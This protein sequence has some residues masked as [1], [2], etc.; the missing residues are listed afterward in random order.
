MDVL[1]GQCVVLCGILRRFNKNVGFI[2][3]DVFDPNYTYWTVK[4]FLFT[5]MY[6]SFVASAYFTLLN[7]DDFVDMV[8]CLLGFGYI[9]QAAYKI[10]VFLA[11][12]VRTV[13]L[14]RQYHEIYAR[15]AV[16]S[17]RKATLDRFMGY[18]LLGCRVI[19]ITYTAWALVIS[20]VPYVLRL[21]MNEFILP[22]AV[23]FPY[24]DPK[25]SPGYEVNYIFVLYAVLLARNGFTSSETYCVA[26]SFM[27]IGQL[28]LLEDMLDDLQEL[29]EVKEQAPYSGIDDEV[30]TKM[31]EVIF[32]HQEHLR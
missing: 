14:S 18:S 4:L 17:K 20:I 12:R 27:G 24:L 7:A 11:F 3:M 23:S 1:N 16:H 10:Y 28:K 8:F 5:V 19:Y 26:H 21:T 22:V 13:E 15:N 32:E 31:N 30:R 29:L 2:G 25:S 9:I 6:I